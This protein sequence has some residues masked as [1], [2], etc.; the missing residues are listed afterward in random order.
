MIK[1]E[2]YDKIYTLLKETT[3]VKVNELVNLLGVSIDTVRRDL[4]HLEKKGVLK[5]VHGGAVSQL[6]TSSDQKYDYEIR[7]TKHLKEKENLAA[8]TIRHV[9]EGQAVALNSG[10]TNIEVAKQLAA[11]FN[12]LTIITNGIK[13]AESFRHKKEFNVIIPGGI[14]DFEE[15][16][17]YGPIC[18]EQIAQYNIDIAFIALNAISL[19]KGFTDF[20]LNEIGTIQQFIKSSQE[21]I[22]VMDSNKFDTVSYIN[23]CAFHDIDLVITDDEI[24]SQTIK[25]Y[26]SS[27]TIA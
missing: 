2:R 4:E 12:K 10:T 17:L 19:Q 15:Y 11:K 7:T 13:V 6:D 3:I 18:E 23:V 25:K 9:K 20:R 26:Q 16:S 5:R 24:K 21:K 27:V 14:L 1:E 8:K 22:I